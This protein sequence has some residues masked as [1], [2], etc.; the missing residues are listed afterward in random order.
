MVQELIQSHQ[1]SKRHAC[2]LLNL[3]RSSA[4]YQPV[5]KNDML[6]R[7]RLRALATQYPAY[8]YLILHGLLKQQGL[9]VN[10]KRTYR[11]YSEEK[12]QM[13]TKQRK[14]L[15]RPFQ[16]RTLPTA[17]NQRWSMDFVAD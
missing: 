10:K 8:G 17:I 6:L 14:K 5:V 7:Q 9:V 13:R 2:R 11:L 16:P 15:K 1:L 12:L 3:S 4:M